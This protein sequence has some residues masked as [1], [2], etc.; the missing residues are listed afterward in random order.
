MKTKQPL[1]RTLRPVLCL[2]YV[3]LLSLSFLHPAT[4]WAGKSTRGKFTPPQS[5]IYPILQYDIPEA[6][7]ITLDNGM[8]LF[9]LE[10]HEL[11][12][13]K[14]SAVIRTGSAYD[15]P[16]QAGLAELTCRSMRTGG[17]AA[18]TGNELDDRLDRYAISIW[19]K[20]DMEMARF[21]LNTLKENLELGIDL[22]S[23]ILNTPRFDPDKVRIEKELLMESLRRIEDDPQEYAFREY[24]KQLYRGNPRGNQSTVDSVEGINPADLAAFHQRYFYPAN[25]LLTV[26]GDI[27]REE[28]VKLL[29]RSFP[30]SRPKEQPAPLPAPVIQG[31]GQVILVPKATPQ[32]IVLLGF[33]APPK[34]TADYYAFSIL[35]FVL[36]SG[37]FDSRIFR[38]IRNNQGLAYSAGSFYKARED[39]GVF[40]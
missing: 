35:D 15:P 37:G 23:Q 13:V 29:S 1:Q 27:S 36:G 4:V 25:I 22:F 30:P 34:T 16:A 33:P 12:L 24:R 11:P 20:T 31:N 32:S 14:I 17:T 21:G 19:A 28:A 18:L 40:S 39:Y 38:E 3:F 26:T 9:L 5:I 2:I 10:N 7:R 6:E 8:A